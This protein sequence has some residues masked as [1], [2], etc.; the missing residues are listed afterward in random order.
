MAADFCLV[1]E[2][3]FTS[4]LSGCSRRTASQRPPPAAVRHGASGSSVCAVRD[5]MLPCHDETDYSSWIDDVIHTGVKLRGQTKGQMS[6][7]ATRCDE[8]I[9]CL[10]ERRGEEFMKI[11]SFKK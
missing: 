4:F 2:A 6:V 9:L 3:N 7:K 11:S 1:V 8:T 5:V 10:E